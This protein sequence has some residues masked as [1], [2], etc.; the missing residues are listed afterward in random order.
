M[1]D[2][3]KLTKNMTLI[4]SDF[5]PAI[6]PMFSGIGPHLAYLGRPVDMTPLYWHIPTKLDI[7]CR[8]KRNKPNTGIF[9]FKS[10]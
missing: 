3:T 10:I 7:D 1:K 8:I 9:A 2:P 5:C 4:S 6:H